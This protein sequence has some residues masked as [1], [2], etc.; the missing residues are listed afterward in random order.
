ML[1]PMAASRVWAEEFSKVCQMEFYLAFF[2]NREALAALNNNSEINH[3]WYFFSY[4]QLLKYF[5]QI[6]FSCGQL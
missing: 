2:L 3:A 5:L 4:T 6:F 1:G